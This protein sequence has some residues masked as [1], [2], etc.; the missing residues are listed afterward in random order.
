MINEKL[1]RMIFG[2][3]YKMLIPKS[4]KDKAERSITQ[5]YKSIPK[6][7]YIIYLAIMT[8]I[9][10]IIAYTQAYILAIAFNISIP[11]KD[12]ILLFPISVIVS[13]LPISISGFGTREASL[14]VVLSK[15]NLNQG[16]IV[17]FSISW[18]AIPLIIYTLISLPLIF[19]KKVK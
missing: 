15:F 13:L 16:N 10:W 11:Y 14:L 4:M 5:F 8:F 17:A 9:F 18:I 1:N 6:L 3:G 19:R 12:F 7:K 2:I